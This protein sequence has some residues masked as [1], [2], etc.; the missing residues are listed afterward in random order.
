MPPRT[1]ASKAAAGPLTVDVTAVLVASDGARWLPEALAAL[2]ASTARPVKVVC[3]DTGST[4]GSADLLRTAYGEVLEL[5]RGTAFGAAVAAALQTA[6]PSRWLW[7]LHDDAA[8]EPDALEALLA[9]AEQSPSAVLLGPKVR[10]WAD[11]RVLVEVGLTTDTAGHRETGLD[12]REYDQGQHDTIRDVLAVGTAGALIRRDVWDELGGLDPT[13]AV[14]RDDLDL[15][16]R[17][18]AAGHRV[19]IVPAARIR[20]VR[21]ATTGRRVLHAASGRPGGIDRRNALYVL[22]AHAAGPR[23]LLALPRLAVGCLL[24][25]IGYLLT[26]QVAAAGDE[27]AALASVVGRPGRLLAARRAR[28]RTRTLSPR[29]IRPL[30]AKRTGR[31]RARFE[32]VAD[33]LSGGAAPGANPLGALGDPGPEGPD[34]LAELAPS[35]GG[36]LKRLM[37]RP[38]VLVTVALAVLAALA[39]R[40]LLPVHRGVLVGGRLLPVPSGAGGLWSSYAAAWHPTAVGTGGAAPPA[41]VLLAALSTLLLGKAWLAVDVLVLAGPAIAGAVAYAAAGRLTAHRLLRMWA[42]ATWALLPVATG[43]VATGRL[44]GVVAQIAVPPLLVAGVGLLRRPRLPWRRAWGLGL[45][46]AMATAFAP[47]LWPMTAALL[48]VGAVLVRSVRRMGAALVVAVVPAVLLLPWT[49]DLVAHPAHLLDGPGLVVAGDRVEPWQL[50]LLHMGGPAQP[51]L[52][53][54][55]GLAAAGLGGLLRRDAQR[56]ALG[57]WV[58]A[59]VGLATAAVLQSRGHSPGV[60]LQVAAAGVLGAA[61]VGG[62]ELRTR[63]ADSDFGWRQLTAAVVVVAAAVT[64]AAAAVSWVARGADGPLHRGQSAVLPA[65]ARAELAATPG[66]RALVVTPSGVGVAYELTSAGGDVLGTGDLPL[67]ATQSDTLDRIVADLLA[68]RGSDAAEALA[69]RAV[70]YV[71]LPAGPSA[72]RYAAALDAQSG[73][74]RRASGRTLLWRVVA[75]TARL[76]LLRPGMAAAALRGDR[77]PTRELLRVAPPATLPARQESAHTRVP[78][79]PPGRLLVLADSA[80]RGWQAS[81]DGR[82]LDRRTAW[83][84]AQAFVVPTSGG[85]LVLS[86]DQSPRHRALAGELLALAVVLVLA[87]PAA[88]RR[89]GLEVV[90]EETTA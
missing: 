67:A 34:E 15:G 9:H 50:L 22:L 3:V 78:A 5:P 26:R 90:D 29:V 66:L 19:V 21:A 55:A 32:A 12:R 6:P 18:N 48:L 60:S 47:L 83:G 56:V 11:P 69:T 7:L 77:G 89:H 72:A 87:A 25:A 13:L 41:T 71:A 43:S 31:L 80:A 36:A 62:N 40:D 46:L 8:V 2:A 75:P 24:R 27:L 17:V 82:P 42:A 49:A 74:S 63:L 33:W 38:G 20:H 23:L 65:F 52:W 76:S 37:L 64:P 57:T 30:L 84:W 61:L 28:A 51:A 39:D 4:D 88:R 35:G 73:L 86:Y 14:F 1:R 70:R 45:G 79:G 10:D 59:L 44:D 58:V 85:A 68:T 16:W 53:V 81:I 54:T